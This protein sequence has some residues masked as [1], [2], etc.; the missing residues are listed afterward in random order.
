MEPILQEI[1]RPGASR[2]AGRKEYQKGGLVSQYPEGTGAVATGSKMGGGV[3]MNPL[4]WRYRFRVKVKPSS[5]E[6]GLYVVPLR[7]PVE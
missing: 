6:A 2:A 7:R 3:G 5:A 4:G 1:E